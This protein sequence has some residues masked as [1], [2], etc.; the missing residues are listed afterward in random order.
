M[1]DSTQQADGDLSEGCESV[2]V[3][4]TITTAL[5]CNA[6]SKSLRNYF[7][8]VNEHSLFPINPSQGYIPQELLSFQ[9]KL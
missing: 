4:S 6:L 5:H 8:P 2:A 3:Q 9:G 7:Y 1:S